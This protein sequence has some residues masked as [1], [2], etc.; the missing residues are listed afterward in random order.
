MSEADWGVMAKSN[1]PNELKPK[2]DMIGTDGKK[3]TLGDMTMTLYLTPGHTP[4]RSRQSS[5][6]A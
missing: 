5:G 3:I 2:K 6:I 1:E 4:A